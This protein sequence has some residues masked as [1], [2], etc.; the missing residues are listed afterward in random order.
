MSVPKKDLYVLLSKECCPIGFKL[1]KD[2]LNDP[3]SDET[4]SKLHKLF[5]GK[6]IL[7]ITQTSIQNRNGSA[8]IATLD[9]EL[10]H[11]LNLDHVVQLLREGKDDLVP[12]VDGLWWNKTDFPDI[13][14]VTFSNVAPVVAAESGDMI[15]LS[16]LIRDYISPETFANI[17]AGKDY[18][19]FYI[20]LSTNYKYN[21]G[22]LPSQIKN[23]ISMFGV[24]NGIE[25]FQDFNDPNKNPDLFGYDESD[26]DIGLCNNIV[27]I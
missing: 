10:K 7:V 23:L 26:P 4:I 14:V 15:F 18:C 17:E 21:N 13:V 12:Q 16:T 20:C 2:Y 3:R 9:E 6:E 8:K 19:H 22:T 1:S 11:D 5:P 25:D 27:A 24:E